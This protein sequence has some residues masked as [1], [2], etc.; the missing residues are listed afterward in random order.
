MIMK[1]HVDPGNQTESSG[2]GLEMAQHL[3]PLTPLPED[4]AVLIAEPFLQPI[5]ICIFK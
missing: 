3:R 4:S 2:R 5:E 1:S